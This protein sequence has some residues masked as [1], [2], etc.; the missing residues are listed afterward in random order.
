[1]GYSNVPWFKLTWF[2]LWIYTAITLFIMFK[3]E[4]F[5]NITICVSAMFM[6]F[7]TDKITKNLFR[8]LVLGIVISIIFD[9]FWF[10]MKHYEYASE[11]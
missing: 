11:S 10:A 3:K 7:N 1:M 6:L 4:D 2:L 5:L 9:L 8:V